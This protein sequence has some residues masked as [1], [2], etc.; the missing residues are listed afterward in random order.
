VAA[1]AS[2]GG[3]AAASARLRELLVLLQFVM[4]VGVVAA[5]LVMDSQMRYVANTPLGFQ[6]ENQVLITIHGLGNFAHVPALARELKRNPQVLAV[7]QAEQPPGQFGN[8]V[9]AG[10]NQK[11]EPFS[12]KYAT[13]GID[14]DFVPTLG[15][16]IVAGRNF[17]PGARAG[18]QFLVNEAF[19][20]QIGWG[21]DVIGQPYF[22]GRIVGVLRDFHFRSLRDPIVPLMLDTIS[23]DPKRVPEARRPFVQRTLIVRISGRDFSGTIRHIGNVMRRFDP[24]N[25]FEYTL[26]D[27]GMRGLYDTERRML[28]LIAVFATLCIFIACLGLFGL[29]A[30]ATERRAR[31]IAIRKVLGASPLQVVW[32]LSRR[33]LL[34]IAIGG[35]IAAAA[36]WLV[37]D[38]WLTGFAYRVGVNPLLLVLSILLAAGVALGTVALQSLRVARADPADTLRYE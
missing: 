20:R 33:V 38:E 7:A 12:M 34:L 28:T 14:A 18:R 36:A 1:F 30:F 9:V 4:A 19:V 11:G 10:T 31:E 29:S 13:T 25:P 24:A 5:A 27:E 3:G 6:R 22:D 35:V 16:S 23:D 8:M 32:L 26:L 17:D 21:D 37:M 15:L 2:R